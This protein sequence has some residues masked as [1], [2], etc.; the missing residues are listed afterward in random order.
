MQNYPFGPD[1]VLNSAKS[2]EFS[3]LL[4]SVEFWRLRPVGTVLQDQN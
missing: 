4:N 2:T 3:T 1:L